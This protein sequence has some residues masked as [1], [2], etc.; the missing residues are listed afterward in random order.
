M[1]HA[2]TVGRGFTAASSAICLFITALWLPRYLTLAVS[3][4]FFAVLAVPFAI[5][6]L[7]TLDQSNQHNPDAHASVKKAKTILMALQG[8]GFACWFFDVISTIFLI[9]ILGI[10]E[11][12]N[13][14][15]WPFSA[16]GALVFYVPMVFVAYF[17]LF[18]VKSKM[19][20]YVTAVISVLVL[21]MGALN[22][23]AAL[24]NFGKIE[25][26]SSLGDFA[27]VG[28]WLGVLVVLAV[29]NVASVRARR[30]A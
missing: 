25:P 30:H 2:K 22:L 6:C 7:K 17:L 9:N 5:N 14:L 3:L 8:F 13:I 11:E 10:A 12:L 1:S 16:L 29:V 27:V 19:S 23:N 4:A 15:G 18:G 28:L 21:F 20:F 24:Y 26:Y